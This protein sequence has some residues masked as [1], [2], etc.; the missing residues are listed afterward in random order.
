MAAVTGA[1]DVTPPS[2]IPGVKLF[3]VVAT[4]G[5]TFSKHGLSRVDACSASYQ[6]TGAASTPLTCSISSGTITITGTGVTDQ[7]VLLTIYGA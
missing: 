1:T 4:S 7:T 2:F 3:T 6:Q 5:E